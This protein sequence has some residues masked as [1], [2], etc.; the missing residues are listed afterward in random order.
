MVSRD[1]SRVLRP[2]DLVEGILGIEADGSLSCANT[3]LWPININDRREVVCLIRFNFTGYDFAAPRCKDLRQSW[4][5]GVY[6]GV[7][8]VEVCPAHIAP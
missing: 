4:Q 5:L 3:S 6:F 7:G 2:V 8:W 1:V